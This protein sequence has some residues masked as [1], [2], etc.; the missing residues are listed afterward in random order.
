[1]LTVTR[2]R[3]PPVQVVIP[4]RAAGA[5]VEVCT[6]RPGVRLAVDVSAALPA[7][8]A[9]PSLGL[10]LGLAMVN[11]L[12]GLPKSS[13]VAGSGVLLGDGSVGRV[14]GLAD[15]ARQANPGCGAGGCGGRGRSAG[16]PGRS[17][18]VLGSRLLGLGGQVVAGAG[19]PVVVAR[20]W[21]VVHCVGR[22]ST[23][24]WP[25]EAIRA[26]VSTT[27]YG[28]IPCGVVGNSRVGVGC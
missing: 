17:T 21:S 28:S 12:A 9:G 18:G 19:G 10:I 5:A 27:P 26:G 14:S 15:K 20:S 23:R 4:P 16:L 13:R 3:V 11:A 7:G 1:M 25:V 22:C 8:V 6:V 2:P 24:R